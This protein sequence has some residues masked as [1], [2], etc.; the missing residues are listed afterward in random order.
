MDPNSPEPYRNV[1]PM[2][3]IL[4]PS[5]RLP[6]EAEW[7]YAALAL[8]GTQD[9]ENWDETLIY[10]WNGLSVRSS[11]VKTMGV[12]MPIF[13]LGMGYNKGIAAFWPDHF[14]FTSSTYVYT[15]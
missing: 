12:F 15:L 13:K 4:L 3:G 10:P 6:S 5:Y 1:R 8:V 2:D 7:A 14:I 9:F 11:D